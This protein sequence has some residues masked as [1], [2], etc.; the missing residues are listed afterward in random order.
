MRHQRSAPPLL[1]LSALAVVAVA[2]GCVNEGA[3]LGFGPDESR[4]VVIQAYLDRDGSRTPTALDTLFRNARVAL[5][6]KGS[7]D[8]FRTAT[9][10]QFGRGIFANVPLGE[11]RATVVPGSIGDSIQVQQVDTTSGVIIGTPSTSTEI[12]VTFNDDTVGVAARLGYPEVSIRQVRALPA[13]RRV[14]IRGIVLAGVQSFRDTTSHVSDSSGALRLTEVSL[15]GGLTGNSPGDSVSVLGLTSSRS[16]QPTL[17]KASIARFATRPAP[18]PLP[19]STGTAA[20]ASNGALDAQLVLITGA[21][22]SDSA[23]IAPDFRVLVSDG[24]GTLTMLLDANISFPRTQFCPGRT[25]NATGVLVPD[26]VGGWMFKPRQLGDVTLNL[27]PCT[28]AP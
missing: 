25:L 27:T 10:D 3:D 7:V 26:G 23:T 28:P 1:R 5:L 4:V 11:Y 2:A 9:T 17:D 6:A 24:T 16:G 20:S 21:Q 14:F 22:I 13:G 19:V 15:R 12:R 8:T 18:I